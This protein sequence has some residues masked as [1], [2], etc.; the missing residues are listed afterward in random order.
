MLVTKLVLAA[1]CC[2]LL[3]TAGAQITITAGDIPQVIGDS[4]QY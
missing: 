2:L 4:F 3:G 1:S